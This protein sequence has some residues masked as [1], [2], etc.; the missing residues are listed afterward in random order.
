MIARAK[1]IAQV[2]GK[3][4]IKPLIKTVVL[5]AKSG[6]FTSNF[7]ND[8]ENLLKIHN[9]DAFSCIPC[10]LTTPVNLEM[11]KDGVYLVGTLSEYGYWEL[12]K[13][14]FCEYCYE[15]LNDP[16]YAVYSSKCPECEKRMRE[17]K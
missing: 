7:L 8:L 13:V 15:S 2:S 11:K 4:M 3:N 17:T 12:M 1:K 9:I 10:D 5:E 14:S 16:K 6:D